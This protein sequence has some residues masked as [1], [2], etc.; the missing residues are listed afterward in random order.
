[1]IEENHCV[2]V[3]RSNRRSLILSLYVDDIRLARNDMELIVA[4]KKWL[5][6]NFEM[7]DMSKANY[8]LE[9][10]ILRDR[11]NRLLS[12]SQKTNIK[13]ILKWFQMKNCRP[14]D[15]PIAKGKNLSFEMAHKTLDE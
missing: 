14:I 1:M 6:S 4:T 10:K 3:K 9:V 12:L 13:K 15:T 11:S 8:V 7:K 5:S 2:Y